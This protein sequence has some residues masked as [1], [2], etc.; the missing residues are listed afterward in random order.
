MVLREHD[1]QD[2]C[3]RVNDVISASKATVGFF[4]EIFPSEEDVSDAGERWFAEVIESKIHGFDHSRIIKAKWCKTNTGC[5]L[6]IGT[7]WLSFE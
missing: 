1:D 3:D 4:L 5:T 7:V 6:K 2:R